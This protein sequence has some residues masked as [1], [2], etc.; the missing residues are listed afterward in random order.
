VFLSGGQRQRLAI[1]RAV[2]HRPAILI[3]DEPTNHLD[4]ASME[5]VMA[6]IAALRP[7]PAVLLISHRPEVLDAVDELVELKEGRV[8]SVGPA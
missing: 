7:R 4:R 1:A 8:I 5:S 2:I 6:N 3:L